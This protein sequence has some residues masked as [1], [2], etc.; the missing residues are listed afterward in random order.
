MLPLCM[1]GEC[2]RIST[3]ICKME[4]LKFLPDDQETFNGLYD[5]AD[6]F[7]HFPYMLYN[8]SQCPRVSTASYEEHYL[9]TPSS[10]TQPWDPACR[11]LPTVWI[12]HK[13]YSMTLLLIFLHALSLL[14][15]SCA[16]VWYPREYYTLLFNLSTMFKAS[17]DG[18]HYTHSSELAFA[19][20]VDFN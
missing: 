15:H 17:M 3:T 9:L 12:S 18:I 10:F 5:H 6:P 7:F 16:D 2:A 14:S 13:C 19:Y 8:L 20:Q 11:R 1:A 4:K